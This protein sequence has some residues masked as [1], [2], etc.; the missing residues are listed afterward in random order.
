[1]PSEVKHVIIYNY[2][3]FPNLKYIYDVVLLICTTIYSYY[4]K[5]NKRDLKHMSQ[6]LNLKKE[7]DFNLSNHRIRQR[8]IKRMTNQLLDAYNK[9]EIEESTF[10]EIIEILLYSFLER[11]FENK[12]SSKINK[13]DEKLY[14][15]WNR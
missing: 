10:K 9:G 15:S 3:V 14:R 4:N 1:M 7:D 13:L 11:S 5:E 12:I 8:E 2:R 6:L